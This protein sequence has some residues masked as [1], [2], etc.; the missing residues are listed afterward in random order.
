MAHHLKFLQVN[1]SVS[2]H[3]YV[4]HRAITMRYSSG[5]NQRKLTALFVSQH[6]SAGL[7]F[8]A[9]LWIFPITYLVYSITMLVDGSIKKKKLFS[10][11]HKRSS[12]LRLCIRN[13]DC[14]ATF[15]NNTNMK[16][17][18]QMEEHGKDNECEHADI[19]NP[20]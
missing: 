18:K 7:M 16:A 13:F 15:Y 4:V 12:D 5:I 14:K 9:K 19:N 17:F 10:Y 2:L 8:R 11:C 3:N 6:V 20:L 1:Y